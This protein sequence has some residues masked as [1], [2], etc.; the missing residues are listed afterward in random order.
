MIY[1][2]SKT[3]HILEFYNGYHWRC[4]TTRLSTDIS[5]L[6]AFNSDHG[7]FQG[8]SFHS[9]PHGLT[10]LYPTHCGIWA[11]LHPGMWFFVGAPDNSAVG[12]SNKFTENNKK[13]W[14][15]FLYPTTYSSGIGPTSHFNLK[16]DSENWFRF[17]KLINNS[18]EL[19][20]CICDTDFSTTSASVLAALYQINHFRLR[21]EFVYR[22]TTRPLML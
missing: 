20:V 3:T 22:D 18:H 15:S 1:D 17:M 9:F 14:L 12:S 4:H 16:I 13:Y 7:A 2:I 6:L 5:V 19:K 11:T 10:S 21:L 8:N